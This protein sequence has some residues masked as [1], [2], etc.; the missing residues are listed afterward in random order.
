MVELPAECQTSW[1][2]IRIGRGWSVRSYDDAGTCFSFVPAVEGQW[3]Y[4]LDV[5]K[6]RSDDSGYV[7][8]ALGAA[9][10]SLW[11][12][13]EVLAKLT[14]E[15]AHAVLR[16]VLAGGHAMICDVHGIEICRM[17]TANHWIA[18][19]RRLCSADDKADV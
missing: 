9:G 19:G 12:E 10:L 16:E 3:N 4:A 1:G 2:L 5:E 14:N 17:D 15:P 6:R 11:V 13:V 18:V 8:S 7:S